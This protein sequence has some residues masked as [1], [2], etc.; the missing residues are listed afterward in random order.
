MPATPKRERDPTAKRARI[1]QAALELFEEQGY[2]E[3]TIDQIAKAA[4]VARRSIFDHFPTKQAIL[5]D[6]L[7]VRRNVAIEHL[8]Q[9]PSSEPPLTSLHLVLR[10]LCVQGYDRRLLG[11]IRAVVATQPQLV[12]EGSDVFERAATATLQRR[13]GASSLEIQAVTE[14]A[15]AWFLTAIRV[16]FR[17]GRR[18]LVS[19]FDEVVAACVSASAADLGA[20]S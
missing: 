12:F 9:R 4:G 3:T 11:Q 13:G 17:D 18:S 15:M 16:Y 19:C 14:M 2:A 7:V 8:A 20:P 10:E 5:F 6:H 1:A